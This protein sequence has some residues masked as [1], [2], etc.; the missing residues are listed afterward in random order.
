MSI[1]TKIKQLRLM[2]GLTQEELADRA[3]L[4]KGFISQLERDLT[5]PSITTLTDILECL[6]TNLKEFFNDSSEEKVVFSQ[7]DMFEKIDKDNGRD[8]L[9]LVPNAQKNTLEPIMMTLEVGASSQVHSAHSGEEFG[10]ILSGSATL[11]L[12]TRKFKL[13][14]GS[15]FYYEA[16]VNHHITNTGK[17]PVKIL[18][19]STPPTF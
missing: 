9:W 19:V 5:S 12:G 1:G 2:N 13:K 15:S 3:E 17:T 4:S 16:N 18:W 6:G 10:Y 11:F 7:D 14:K 8:I